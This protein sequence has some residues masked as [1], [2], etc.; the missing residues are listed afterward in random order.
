M[1]LSKKK[2]LHNFLVSSLRTRNWRVWV[3]LKKWSKT[4]PAFSDFSYSY[5]L[6]Q[7]RPSRTDFWQQKSDCL[8]GLKIGMKAHLWVAWLSGLWQDTVTKKSGLEYGAAQ[9]CGYPISCCLQSTTKSVCSTAMGEIFSKL[10]V[11]R[12]TCYLSFWMLK[13]L[14]YTSP[15]QSAIQRC[16]EDE[17][18]DDL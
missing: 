2:E 1:K 3:S 11:V 13:P 5:L 12:R 18:M 6:E 8:T 14:F 17:A 16:C 15:F 4:S 7:S 10:S 9:G